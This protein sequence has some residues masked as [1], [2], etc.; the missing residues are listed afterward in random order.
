[1]VMLD[2]EL[3]M[4]QGR[5]VFL[6]WDPEINGP[7]DEASDAALER[8]V[9]MGNLDRTFV[10]NGEE[11][12]SAEDLIAANLHDPVVLVEAGEL[13]VGETA[14]GGAGGDARRIR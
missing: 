6:G 13:G 10:V 12:C 4:L 7:V 14:G 9:A 8:F 5:A 3:T 11:P 2:V 1:M